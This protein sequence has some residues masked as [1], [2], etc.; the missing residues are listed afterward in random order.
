MADMGRPYYEAKMP[1]NRRERA[2]AASI[3]ETG[4]KIDFYKQNALARRLHLMERWGIDLVLDLGANT[5]QYARGLRRAGYAGRIVSFEPLSSAHARLA[6]NARGDRLWHAERMGLGARDH[7]A[8]LTVSGDSRASSLRDMLPRHRKVAS[9]FAPVGEEQVPIRK[10]DTVWDEHVPRGSS[11]YLK[12]DTQ[13][14]ERQV[15]AGAA[16]SLPKVRAV[17]MEISL[18]ALYDGDLLLPEVLRLMTKKGF[19]LVSVEYG[20]CDP[21]TAE[22]LQIDGIFART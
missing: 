4:R 1:T 20:F 12:I 2:L 21:E 6:R 3:R 22:M 9:Y 16:R 5:G 17:Q 11:V 19:S 15:L 14:Y 18:Q 8:T 13:G 10:L 7:E